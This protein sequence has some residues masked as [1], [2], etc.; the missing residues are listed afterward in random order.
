MKS[1][2]SSLLLVRRIFLVLAI[3]AFCALL[4]VQA[5]P[6][7]ATSTSQVRVIQASPDIET[8]VVFVDGKK[9][10]STFTFAVVTDYATIPAGPHKIQVA[11]IGRG[12]S[13]PVISQTLSVNPGLA[14]TVAAVGTKSTGLSLEV[15]TDDNQLSTAMAK[16]RIYHLSSG[17]GALSVST[18]TKVL[19]SG[20]RSRQ[21][22]NYLTL[23]LGSYTFNLEL[24]K[25]DTKI[26][27]SATLRANTV[28]S[29]FIVGGLF[30]GAPRLQL[31]MKQ[32]PGLPGQPQ[33]S[34]HSNTGAVP[35]SSQPLMPWFP[36]VVVVLVLIVIGV[37]FRFAPMLV[38][39]GTHLLPQR[40]KIPVTLPLQ[41][42]AQAQHSKKSGVLFLT[43]LALL[44]VLGGVGIGASLWFYTNQH[45]ALSAGPSSRSSLVQPSPSP[46]VNPE[47]TATSTT[48]P[49][50][51]P[52]PTLARLYSGTMR[53]I[54]TGLTTSISL[55]SIRQQQANVSGYFSVS[56][57]NLFSEIPKSGPFQGTVSTSKEVQFTLLDNT[58]QAA[59]SFNGSILADKSIEGTYCSLQVAA[60]KC[61]DY[62]LWS[63]SLAS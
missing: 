52:Y 53:D 54:P 20:L 18:G 43:S 19:L 22:S 21:A 48:V 9:L 49:V 25:P 38:K 34:A 10:L 16:V 27:V 29:I 55:T 56:E 42:Q 14:Y 1:R 2:H 37:G 40:V 32:V 15:F 17:T 61:S 50:S 30:K 23:P 13:A 28:S 5:E 7:A 59:F 57:N 24:I 60:G 8:V 33:R 35:G 51:P 4:A 63:V 58:G 47:P 46:K 45:N 6:A 31:V 44:A 26:Q 12:A 36:L 62:G 11:T 39:T 3:F 41:G